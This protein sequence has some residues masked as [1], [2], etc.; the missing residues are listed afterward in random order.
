MDGPALQA[1]MLQ[2]EP[3]LLGL[4]G[5]LKCRVPTG[6]ET[7][8]DPFPQDLR[9]LHVYLIGAVSGFNQRFTIYTLEQGAFPFSK[10]FQIKHFFVEIFPEYL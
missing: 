8:L 4:R 2:G 3:A 5:S 7:T 9:A 1:G 10:R 6:S